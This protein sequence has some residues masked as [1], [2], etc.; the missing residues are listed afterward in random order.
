MKQTGFVRKL[1]ELGRIVIPIEVRRTLGWIDNTPIE[2]SQFGRYIFLHE[3]GDRKTSFVELGRG[4][5]VLKELEEI[6]RGLP[7][8]DML[9][10]LELLHRLAG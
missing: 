10:V 3:R 2:I 5:P 4:N 9:L 6:L 7:D 8:Q 1:D